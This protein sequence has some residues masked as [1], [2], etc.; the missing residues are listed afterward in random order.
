MKTYSV[1]VAFHT[2]NQYQVEAGSEEEAQ[3]KAEALAYD[4]DLG[5]FVFEGVETICVEEVEQK[6]VA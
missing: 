5:D 6:E 1:S 3:E 2:W 4:E